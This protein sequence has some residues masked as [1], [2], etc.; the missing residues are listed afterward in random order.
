MCR[1]GGYRRRSGGRG[2]RRTKRGFFS[3]ILSSIRAYRG[4][5]YAFRLLTGKKM[6]FSLRGP[7]GMRLHYNSDGSLRSISL[8]S[9]AGMRVILG[10]NGKFKKLS[11]PGLLKG[12]RIFTNSKGELTGFGLPGL[13]GGYHLYDAHGKHKRSYGPVIKGVCLSEDSNGN[14]RRNAVNKQEKYS[15]IENESKTEINGTEKAYSRKGEVRGKTVNPIDG[16][17]LKKFNLKGINDERKTKKNNNLDLT[18]TERMNECNQEKDAP[19]RPIENISSTDQHQEPQITHRNEKEGNS[20]LKQ[21]TG[22]NTGNKTGVSR[23]PV[24]HEQTRMS[25]GAFQINWSKK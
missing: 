20:N 21:I 7:A 1:G 19:T 14:K 10:S 2:R 3:R 15:F 17:E 24:K 23:Q 22:E 13:F 16:E 25:G 4:T 5:R 8:K 11:I 18:Q 9:C 12:T 6:G